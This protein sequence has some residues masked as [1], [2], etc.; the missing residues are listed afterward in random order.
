MLYGWCAHIYP[1]LLLHLILL[2]VNLFKLRR[3]KPSV[4]HINP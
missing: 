4:R 1:V 2:P 3:I